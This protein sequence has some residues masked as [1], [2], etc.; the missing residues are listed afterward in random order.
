MTLRPEDKRYEIADIGGVKVARAV[1]RE[2]LDLWIRAS[3]FLL[4]GWWFSLIW[5]SAAWLMGVSL[6]ALPI[7]FWMFSKSAFITTLRLT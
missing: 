3:F 5:L 6:I 4:V 2:Q 1:D 7:A